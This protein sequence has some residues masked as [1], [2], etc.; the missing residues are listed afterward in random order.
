M[1]VGR[2][3][4]RVRERERGRERVREREEER[5]REWLRGAAG[6]CL[7]KSSLDGLEAKRDSIFIEENK[8]RSEIELK[9][10]V[11]VATLRP[12]KFCFRTKKS[13]TRV[14]EFFRFSV[15]K[16]RK[17]FFRESPSFENF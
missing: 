9:N 15:K 12:E 5:E 8:Q 10:A 11:F 7:R 16:V 1:P 13:S 17:S 3:E 6:L 4:K 14:S 2:E